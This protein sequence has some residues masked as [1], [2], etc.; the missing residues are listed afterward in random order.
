MI[1]SVVT[2]AIS[3]IISGCVTLAVSIVTNNANSEKTR[4]LL[5]YKLQDLT[6]KVEKHNQVIERVYKLEQKVEDMNEGKNN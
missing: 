4:A 1:V 5:E 2:A 6:D 3:A